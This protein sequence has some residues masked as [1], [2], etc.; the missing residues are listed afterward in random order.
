MRFK[1]NIR[2]AVL[3][4]IKSLSSKN[5]NVKY[6][7][8]VIDVFTK[9]AWVKPL[10]DKKGKTVLNTFIEIVNE[11]NCKPNKLWVDQGREFY[12]KLMQEWLGS[13]DILMYSTLSEGKSVIAE[14][15]IKTLKAEI[16]K[17]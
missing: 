3:A 7:L 11:S 5:K 9:Y 16:Y 10:K 15:F 14:R 17:K 12:N 6:L 4:E 1:D 2:T 8:C 13:N